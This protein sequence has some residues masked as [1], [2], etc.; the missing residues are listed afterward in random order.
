MKL[1]IALTLKKKVNEAKTLAELRQRKADLEDQMDAIVADGGKA[2]LTDPL[3]IEYKDIVSQIKKKNSVREAMEEG[4]QLFLASFSETQHWEDS[5]A[6]AAATISQKY[7]VKLQKVYDDL[8]GVVPSEEELMEGLPG[9]DSWKT[10]NP[11]YEMEGESERAIDA[12]YSNFD[13]NDFLT[14]P[15]ADDFDYTNISSNPGE[16]HTEDK[17]Y[18]ASYIIKSL[19]GYLSNEAD[20]ELDLDL[21]NEAKQLFT[22][23][24]AEALQKA[25]YV[26]QFELE[27]EIDM[28]DRE[29]AV[30]KALSIYEMYTKKNKTE[31]KEDTIMEIAKKVSTNYAAIPVDW[32]LE[33]MKKKL[34]EDS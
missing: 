18:P 10:T 1:R 3:S 29:D 25:G 16:Y 26:L 19:A 31:D 4:T 28:G 32:L 17:T 30:K 20:P 11:E 15:Y 13:L 5:L 21:Q 8:D 12:V 24:V 14:S 6:E 33:Q 34:E 27:E 22:E 7:K 2:L 9:Y 23:Q